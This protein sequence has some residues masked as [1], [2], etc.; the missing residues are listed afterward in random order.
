M[1]DLINLIRIAESYDNIN[2]ALSSIV[3][4]YTNLHNAVSILSSGEFQLSSTAGSV[5]EEWAPK[6]YHYFMSTTRT[7]FGGFHSRA[8]DGGVMF[9]LDGNYYNSRYKAAPVDYWTQRDASVS[10]RASEAEDRIFSKTPTIPIDGV[11]SIHVYVKPMDDKDRKWAEGA[12]GWAR[13][14]L[15]LSKKR[16]IPAYLYEDEALWRRQDPAGHVQITKRET[17]TGPDLYKSSSNSRR[18]SDRPNRSFTPWFELINI[19]STNKLGKEA[20]SYAYDL[21]YDNPYYSNSLIQS[22]KN[23]LSNARK[24]NSG[25]DRES[26]VKFLQWMQQNRLNTVEDA[27]NFLAKKWKGIK[28]SENND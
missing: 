27:V 23:N 18:I 28:Q 9:D 25:N 5:E 2:E 21:S 22:L 4:H 6:G 3:Y 12:P 8:G 11:T 26:A 14:V 16:G 15:L 24:P 7:K 20:R 1:R 19:N 10:Q 13:K 17:L